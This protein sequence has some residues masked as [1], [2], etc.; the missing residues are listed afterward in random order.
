MAT[1][2]EAAKEPL[3][4]LNKQVDQSLKAEPRAVPIHRHQSTVPA[5]DKDEENVGDM[6]CVESDTDNNDNEAHSTVRQH[7]NNAGGKP[8][9][10]HDETDS[11]LRDDDHGDID[12][13]RCQDYEML[14]L[15]ETSDDDD[16]DFV[17]R[18]KTLKQHG[19]ANTQDSSGSE[20]LKQRQVRGISNAGHKRKRQ[21]TTESDTSASDKHRSCLHTMAKPSSTKKRA[22]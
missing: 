14:D 3:A 21:D 11:E 5:E 7:A 1:A 18:D 9:Q 16:G 10:L 13:E 19:T 20:S 8:R 15:Q 17:M 22:I 6:L 2:R 4:N 12:E